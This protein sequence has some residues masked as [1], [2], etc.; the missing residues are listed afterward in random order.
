MTFRTKTTALF[1]SAAILALVASPTLANNGQEKQDRN[2]P[3]PTIKMPVRANIRD[4]VTSKSQ[5]FKQKVQDVKDRLTEKRKTQLKSW[6]TRASKRLSNI[7]EHLTKIAD[8]ISVRLD[9]LA[10]N[11]KDVTAQRTELTAARAKIVVA[12]NSIASASLQIDSILAN[13]TPTDAFRKLHDLQ[14]GVITKIRDAHRALV[15]LLASIRNV[16][17]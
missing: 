2:T 12:S 11:G 9:K 15:T 8:K 14:S 6:W 7:T 13:N 17:P 4:I 16:A 5:E 1:A 10:A 3:R